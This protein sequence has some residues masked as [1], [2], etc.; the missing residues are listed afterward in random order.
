MNSFEHD[1]CSWKSDVYD[2]F[3]LNC[4]V[5]DESRRIKDCL[6]KTQTARI[7]TWKHGYNKGLSGTAEDLF[8][9]RV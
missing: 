5:Y 8:N 3:P 7:M 9:F 1:N 4:V 2:F 6:P